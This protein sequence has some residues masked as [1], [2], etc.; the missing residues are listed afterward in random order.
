MAIAADEEG[1][2]DDYR[3]DAVA[4]CYQNA[5]ESKWGCDDFAEGLNTVYALKAKA[6]F[7]A[8]IDEQ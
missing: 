3:P 1:D 7:E 5:L 8:F 2:R 6:S 4:L